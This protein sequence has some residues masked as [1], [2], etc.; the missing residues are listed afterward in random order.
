MATNVNITEPPE[1]LKSYYAALAERGMNLGNLGF[2]PYTQ[3]RV[4]PWNQQQDAAAEMIQQRALMGSPAMGQ[5]GDWYSQMMGGQIGVG[6]VADPGTLTPGSNPY[7]GQ[8]N[9]YLNQAINSAM[10][11]VSSRINSQFNNTAFGGTAHQQTLQRGLGDVANQM[12]MQDYTQ[13]QGLQ[14]NAL[15]RGM[16]SGQFNISNQMNTNQFNAGLQGQN[17]GR[18]QSMMNFAPTLA[19]NDYADAQAM[20]GL[21][22]QLQGY[23]Q[24]IADANYQEFL[25]QQNYPAQ[26]LS[27]MQAGLNPAASAFRNSTTTGPDQ[28]SS[29]MANAFGGAALGYAAGNALG[30]ENP[31]WGAMAGGILGGM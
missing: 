2:T 17:I 11:D 29:G 16:Q 27:Y 21:G 1:F 8:D 12:R 26:Q 20:M 31:W 9:P 19:A 23:N 18:Q 14:E 25:R 30:F 15:N 13:Q 24:Q 6:D 7:M 22:S 28:Q 4:A 3:D 5:A 10:G